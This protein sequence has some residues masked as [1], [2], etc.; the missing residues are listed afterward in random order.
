MWK[1]KRRRVT[2]VFHFKLGSSTHYI[3]VLSRRYV[4]KRPKAILRLIFRVCRLFF[5]FTFPH[6]GTVP[7]LAA[8][9]QKKVQMQKNIAFDM[10]RA[11]QEHSNLGAHLSPIWMKLCFDVLYIRSSYAESS[12]FMITCSA[13]KRYWNLHFL[14]KLAVLRIFLKNCNNYN[15]RR[16]FMI[17]S[18]LIP[19]NVFFLLV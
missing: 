16:I 7:A 8:W 15:F 19:L 3:I 9:S 4:T 6:S 5:P 13:W 18:G 1:R 10:G 17:L 14:K 11:S 12:N 2:W